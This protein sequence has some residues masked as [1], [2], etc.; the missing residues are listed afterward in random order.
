MTTLDA[1]C[2][3]LFICLLLCGC[4]RAPTSSK[5]D[6][7]ASSTPD[8]ASIQ[9]ASMLTFKAQDM[10]LRTGPKHAIA[11]RAGKL[12]SWG[13]N[14]YG[15][16]GRGGPRPEARPGPVEVLSD[17]AGL[18]ADLDTGTSHTCALMMSG[19]IS[20]WGGNEYRQLGN[21]SFD[22]SKQP[23]DVVGIDGHAVALSVSGYYGCALIRD[24][25]VRCWGSKMYEDGGM[26]GP[27]LE[28]AIA[29][30]VPGL[31]S[32]VTQ[33]A[34]G[35]NH[36]CALRGGLTVCWGNNSLG[37]L[38]SKEVSDSTQPIPVAW[39][40]QSVTQLTAGDDFTC[41]LTD[42]A[43]VLCWG[44]GSH[45]QKGEGATQIK[46]QLIDFGDA[47]Q[48]VPVQVTA[49]STHACA[50]FNSGSVMCWGS[51]ASGE[52]GATHLPNLPV[53]SP[54]MVQGL[55]AKALDVRAGQGYTCV[56]L[57]G[58]QITCWGWN[59]YGQLGRGEEPG[60]LTT[61]APIE[62]AQTPPKAPREK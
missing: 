18:V 3:P 59:M 50:R 39:L 61:P 55:G 19:D 40:K 6:L 9:T 58:E 57:P 34:V 25:S 47:V 23:V 24:G 15:Q 45:H 56:R 41:A 46:P 31:S 30:P 43:E 52:L 62:R 22:D 1:L 27:A 51:N 12:V 49:G 29:T 44:D 2:V 13:D 60:V 8:A 14:D 21:G 35:T 32:G 11:T 4:E 17:R 5:P 16:L 54:L 48:G 33:I 53:S 38:A 42:Q 20:C 26:M 10:L 37:Q 36:A 28:H 7:G